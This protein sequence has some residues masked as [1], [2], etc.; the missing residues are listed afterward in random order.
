MH[1][2]ATT[3]FQRWEPENHIHHLEKF[4][5]RHESS[6]LTKL[7]NALTLKLCR[8][9]LSTHQEEIY[10]GSL[11]LIRQVVYSSRYSRNDQ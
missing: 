11:V 9:L 6:W 2:D 10:N 5:S 8:M 1:K 4:H 7:A 3:L